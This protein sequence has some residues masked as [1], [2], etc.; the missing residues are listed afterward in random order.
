MSN[1]IDH[2]ETNQKQITLIGTIHT[3]FQS[4]NNVKHLIEKTKPD[5]VCIELCPKRYGI[6]FHGNK[7][8]RVRRDS[9]RRMFEDMYQSMIGDR[10]LGQE[11][12]IA[13]QSALK[14]D[15]PVYP[16]DRDID[17]T[18]GELIS[19]LN[20]IEKLILVLLWLGS[21]IIDIEDVESDEAILKDANEP[22]NLKKF[23]KI[24]LTKRNEFM[25]NQIVGLKEKNIFVVVG[26]GHLQGLKEELVKVT[27]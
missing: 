11:S 12:I 14:N 20:I 6:L 21:R 19:S 25:A 23:N 3:S 8:Q 10:F 2:I 16:I 22:T 27:G 15:I 17:Q 13:N 18:L 7:I 1:I 26:A 24:F 4:A 5:A 9:L